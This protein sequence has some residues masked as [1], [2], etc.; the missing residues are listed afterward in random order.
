LELLASILEPPVKRH[1][2]PPFPPQRPEPDQLLLLN[3]TLSPS[4]MLS[5]TITS[6][7]ST[8]SPTHKDF[9]LVAQIV[10][11]QIIYSSIG[12]SRGPFPCGSLTNSVQMF[13][14]PILPLRSQ[15]WSSTA[16]FRARS[17]PPRRLFSPYFMAQSIAIFSDMSLCRTTSRTKIRWQ[18]CSCRL[19]EK[20]ALRACRLWMELTFL[21]RITTTPALT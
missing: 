10:A 21:V 8:L 9:I 7:D 13:Q 12:A 20:P 19:L 5:P 14:K 4:G 3:P 1:L 2:S 16:I 6:F 11:E 17:T 18:K 15:I